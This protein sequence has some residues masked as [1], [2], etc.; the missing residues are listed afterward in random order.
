MKRVKTFVFVAIILACI[1]DIIALSVSTVRSELK[2]S[3]NPRSIYDNMVAASATIH[4]TL[5]NGRTGG[6]AGVFIADNKVATAAHIFTM[7]NQDKAKVE[8]RDGTIRESTSVYIDEATDVAIIT[9]DI[10]E[11]AIAHPGRCPKLGEDVYSIGTPFNLQFKFTLAKGIVS[12]P[13]RDIFENVDLVQVDSYGAGGCSGGPAY[14][15][16]GELVG[17][18]L[19]GMPT[20]GSLGFFKK[21]EDVMEVYRASLSAESD[22][23]DI[24]Q[25]AGVSG[26]SYKKKVS[27]K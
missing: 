21:I 8:L 13:G 24:R 25:G 18:M 9:V 5:P 26:F 14:N 15:S 3:H 10:E 2:E 17:I 7:I 16:D 6:G 23:I 4:V 19:A 11:M 22:R 27:R 1:G 20:G 12:H